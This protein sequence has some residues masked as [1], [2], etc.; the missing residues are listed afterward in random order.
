[1][2][3]STLFSSLL[4]FGER[5]HRKGRSPGA[6]RRIHSQAAYQQSIP[7][8]GIKHTRVYAVL[9]QPGFMAHG[10][11][12]PKSSMDGCVMSSISSL[13]AFARAA[14]ASIR[15]IS[16]TSFLVSAWLESQG[17]FFSRSVLSA[18]HDILSLLDLL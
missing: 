16:S 18:R 5:T 7:S 11:I 10:T 6:D 3:L 12:L 15:S 14:H 9:C 4:Q 8:Q 17:L 1:M 2:V 13:L